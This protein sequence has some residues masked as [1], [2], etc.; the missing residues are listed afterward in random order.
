MNQPSDPLNHPYGAFCDDFYLNMRLGSQMNLPHGRETVLHFFEQ[1]QKGF[2]SMT[3]FRKSEGGELNLE[4][5]RNLSSY[6]WMSVEAKRL[7]CGR[8]DQAAGDVAGDRAAS[9]GTVSGRDRLP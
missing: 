7:A 3:R 4:E 6:R 1:V 5:D 2:P 9:V 8:G